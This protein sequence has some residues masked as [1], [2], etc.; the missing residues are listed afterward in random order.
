MTVKTAL[1]LKPDNI[2]RQKTVCNEMRQLKRQGVYAK[3]HLNR[4]HLML[5]IITSCQGFIGLK[6]NLKDYDD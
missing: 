6:I 2:R 3:G 5:T 4:N 1:S